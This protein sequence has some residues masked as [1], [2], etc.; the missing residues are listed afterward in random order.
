MNAETVQPPGPNRSIA[1]LQRHFHEVLGRERIQALHRELPWL[2][3]L[4]L[5]ALP[6]VFLGLAV[7]LGRR[8]IDIGWA[9]A[10]VAQGFVLMQ[11][12]LACHEWRHRGYPSGRFGRFV[13]FLL[14][15]PVYRSATHYM[16]WHAIHHSH[17]GQPGDSEWFKRYIDTP[18]R[19]LL[20]A[21]IIGVAFPRL[22]LP[23]RPQSLRGPAKPYDAATAAAITREKRGLLLFTL[24]WLALAAVWPREVL[25]GYLLPL[26]VVTPLAST[27]RTVIE[28]STFDAGNPF[29]IA[30]HYRTTPLTRIIFFWNSGDCHLVH[31][32]F[33]R[34]PF[35]RIPQA[36]RW[37]RPEFLRHGVTDER[38]LARL[39]WEWFT[40]RRP[41]LSPRESGDA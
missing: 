9:A 24:A 36:L 41:Y 16:Y 5:I 19:R 6:S 13:H 17:L 29:A 10:F 14:L 30:C 15:M 38:S 25:L 18:W 20:H 40:R 1:L 11:F 32:V 7:L 2:D 23:R 28:H 34:M 39:V 31:H 21:T 4:A 26:V 8:P 27:V 3:A 22:V 12:G 37:M 33:P 35:Y